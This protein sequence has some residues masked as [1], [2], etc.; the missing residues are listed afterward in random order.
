[1]ELHL[2]AGKGIAMTTHEP[3]EEELVEVELDWVAETAAAVCLTD[4]T[5]EAWVG[6]RKCEE[7]APGV[8]SISLWIVKKNGWES[9]ICS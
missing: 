6:K 1:M 3:R 5:T 4:G 7:L 8:Y 2:L 9:S